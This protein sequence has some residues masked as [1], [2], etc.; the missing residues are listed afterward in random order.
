MIQLVPVSVVLSATSGVQP[1]ASIDTADDS[2]TDYW[3][4]RL[5]VTRDE[6]FDAIGEVG[7]SVAAVRRHLSR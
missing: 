5:N 6:L 3:A 2:Q 7:P 4:S 1:A